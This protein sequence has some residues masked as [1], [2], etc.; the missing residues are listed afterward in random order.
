MSK[1]PTP[2]KAPASI[3]RIERMLAFMLIALI[4]ISLLCFVAVIAGTS[5]GVG[6]NDG[7]SHG[8]WPAVFMVPYLG[9]PLAFLMLVGLL[10]SN[11]IRRQRAA[12]RGNR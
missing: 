7:F 4:A 2:S 5:L 10:V 8:V 12:T 1:N 9:L 3:N 6:N 11:G